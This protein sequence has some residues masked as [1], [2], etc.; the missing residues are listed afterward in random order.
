[1]QTHVK[2]QVRKALNNPKLSM[3]TNVFSPVYSGIGS[4][5]MFH[6]VVESEKDIMIDGLEVTAAELEKTIQYFLENN[7]DI[8]SLER[9]HAIITGKVKPERKF[10][11]FTFDDGYKDNY[12]IAYPIFKKHNVPFT[13]YVTTCFPNKTAVIWWYALE[14]LV[15][16]VEQVEF[17]FKGKDHLY[18]ARTREEENDASSILRELIL[19]LDVEEQ[20]HLFSLLFDRN[21]IDLRQFSERMTMDWQDIEELSRDGLVTIGAHTSNHYNLKNLDEQSVRREIGDSKREIESHIGQVVEHFAFPFGSRNEAGIRE[22]KVAEELGFKTSTTVRCGNIF[23]SHSAH[24]NCLPRISHS[25]VLMGSFPR[26]FANGFVP[27][28]VHKFKRVVT[29]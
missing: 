14:E 24:T 3:V 4:V 19:S 15:R 22:F 20:Q 11:V 7:Y 23:P 21:C 25:P 27:A 16:K 26:I 8:V 5:L 17:H 10:A 12:T 28:I 1:M 29:E 9:A 13:I 2:R 18:P 6:R